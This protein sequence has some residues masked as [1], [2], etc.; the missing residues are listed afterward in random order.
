MT[1]PDIAYTVGV[2]VQFNSNPG[3]A[4]WKATK[5]FFRYLKGTLEMKLGP[6]PTTGDK[7]F[8]TYSDADHDGDKD[9]GKST[10]VL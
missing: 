6:D 2:L 8:V 7:M 4:H 10:T 9:N 1:H 5:H 3:M